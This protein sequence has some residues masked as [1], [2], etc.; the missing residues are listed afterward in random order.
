MTATHFCPLHKIFILDAALEDVLDENDPR[1]FCERYFGELLEAVQMKPLA[2]LSVSPATDPQ[3]PGFSGMQEL[4]TSHASFHYFWEPHHPT[5]N[6]NV[7]IDLYSC[8][9]FSYEEV[10]RVAHS[11]FG[12]DEWTANFIERT[13]NP[14]DRIALQLKGRGHDIIESMALSAQGMRKEALAAA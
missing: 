2:P 3:A 11:H 4:T 9:P 14:L 10:I 5:K 13:L 7:H 8:G 6:P 1:S 12:F